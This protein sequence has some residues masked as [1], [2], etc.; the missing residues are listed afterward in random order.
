VERVNC[1]GYGR[2]TLSMRERMLLFLKPLSWFMMILLKC[3]PLS[4]SGYRLHARRA[5]EISAKESA[6]V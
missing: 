1:A 2:R 5:W 4:I 3:G 6:C